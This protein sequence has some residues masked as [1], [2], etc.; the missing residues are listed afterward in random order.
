MVRITE[1]SEIKKKI[2]PRGVDFHRTSPTD[3]SRSGMK[4]SLAQHQT[5]ARCKVRDDGFDS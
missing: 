3:H 2:R 5:R 1:M 4:F